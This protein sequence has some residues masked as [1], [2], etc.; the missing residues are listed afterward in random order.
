MTTDMLISGNAAAVMR[1][2]RAWLISISDIEGGALPEEMFDCASNLIVAKKIA[3]T[4]AESF[5]Y[6]APFSWRYEENIW[7]L[8]ATFPL[9][10]GEPVPD[11]VYDD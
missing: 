3:R 6:I 11:D 9:S 1:R 10:G 2:N 5:G 7:W 4:M 8:T